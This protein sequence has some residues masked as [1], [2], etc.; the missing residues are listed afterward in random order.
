MARRALRH[1]PGDS[2]AA[3]D[4]QDVQPIRVCLKSGED[5]L[6]RLALLVLAVLHDLAH[7]VMAGKARDSATRMG[8]A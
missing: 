3:S 2:L 6:S 1:V 5:H 4:R 8:R 7:H